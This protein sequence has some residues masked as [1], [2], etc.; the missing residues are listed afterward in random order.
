MTLV[1]WLLV[2]WGNLNTERKLLTWL[3][4]SAS[5]LLILLH[6]SDAKIWQNRITV[7]FV[8]LQASSISILKVQSVL[9]IFAAKE[10][11][12]G[13]FKAM[14]CILWHLAIKQW[15][16]AF[17]SRENDM[18]NRQR[19]RGRRKLFTFADRGPLWTSLGALFTSLSKRG[20]MVEVNSEGEEETGWLKWQKHDISLNHLA[21]A[22]TDNLH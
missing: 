10:F 11:L 2:I 20:K 3:L 17:W 14:F 9:L 8:Q 22:Q 1:I 13:P 12:S 15:G 18:E 19:K 16:L 21:A 7:V 5:L 6:L 4:L